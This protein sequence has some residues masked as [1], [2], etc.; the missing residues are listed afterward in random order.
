MNNPVRN[1]AAGAAFRSI[2]HAP[3]RSA[4]GSMG[5]H[6]ATPYT[7]AA[8]DPAIAL[9]LMQIHKG[10]VL[11]CACGAELGGCDCHRGRGTPE[12]IALLQARR[13]DALAAQGGVA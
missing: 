5:G 7:G 10:V 13:A 9:N 2:L 8:T 4:T 11:R 12:R 6:Q 3:D 1:N